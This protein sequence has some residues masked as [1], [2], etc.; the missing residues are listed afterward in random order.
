MCGLHKL[1]LTI[2]DQAPLE[3]DL[4]SGSNSLLVPLEKNVQSASIS[5]NQCIQNLIKLLS[6]ESKITHVW[7]N[8]IDTK[9]RQH[10]SQQIRYKFI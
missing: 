3:G 7:S 10:Q 8:S 1:K 9:K 6:L 4:T 5:D 2:S